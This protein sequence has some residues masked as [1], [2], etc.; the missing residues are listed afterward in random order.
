V[1]ALLMMLTRLLLVVMMDSQ[2]VNLDTTCTFRQILIGMPAVYPVPKAVCVL[3][4]VLS[5]DSDN[6]K[7]HADGSS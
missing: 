6:K 7:M 5:T 4:G 3:A 2:V 1:N